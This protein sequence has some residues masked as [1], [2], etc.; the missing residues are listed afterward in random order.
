M[1][2]SACSG[3]SETGE[4]RFTL[5]SSSY[6]DIAIG[7]YVPLDS[8]LHR[9]DPRTKLAGL[10]V[11]LIM[12]F[13]TSNS[14]GLLL[15]TAGVLITAALSRVG[16]RLWAQGVRRFVLLLLITTVTTLLF[17]RQGHPLSVGG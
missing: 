10:S 15:S 12:V 3:R 13:S 16:L 17:R 4:E 8:V 9:L 7:E 1:D 5:V 2:N 6:T 14:A 11:A